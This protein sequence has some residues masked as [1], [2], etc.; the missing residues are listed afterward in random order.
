[1]PFRFPRSAF[2]TRPEEHLIGTPIEVLNQRFTPTVRN[3]EKD[4]S[5]PF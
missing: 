4:A 3:S 1:L 2:Y 5:L